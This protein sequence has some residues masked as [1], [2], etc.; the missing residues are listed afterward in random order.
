MAV[1]LNKYQQITKNI[2]LIADGTNVGVIQTENGIILV[3]AGGTSETGKAIMETV[4]QFFPDKEITGI[5]LTHA[6][7]D[8]VGGLTYILEH[9]NPTGYAGKVTAS[10]LEVPQATAMIYAGGKPCKVMRTTEFLMDIPVKTDFILEE[11]ISIDIGGISVRIIDLPGHCPGMTGFIFSDNEAGKKVFF[12]GDAFFGMKMLKKIWIPFILDPADFRDSVMKIEQTNA[13]FF[14]P[15]HGEVCTIETA[16]CVAEHNIMITYEFED[17]IL[18]LIKSG[19]NE[20]SRI[21]ES[22]AN[23]AG[24][25]LKATNYYLIMTTLKSYMASLEEEEQIESYMENNALLWRLKNE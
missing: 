15:G 18:K 5:F 21:L 3:D 22:T 6:H 1:N 17:L 7:T 10:F 24:M 14:I 23:Y 2:G 13:D 8:H 16:G 4:H 20:I 12:L 25:K 9:C 19:C 11:N